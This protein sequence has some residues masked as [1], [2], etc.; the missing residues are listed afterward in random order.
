MT[1]KQF[2]ILT[3]ALF[4]VIIMSG[5]AGVTTTNGGVAPVTMGMNL[6]SDVSGN[7]ILQPIQGQD[8]QIVKRNV[9]ACGKLTSFFTAIT[10]GDVSY[11]TLK[12]K[13]LQHAPGAHDLID[14]K[15]DYHMKNMCGINE[16]TVTLTGTAVKFK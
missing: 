10:M 5:C 8:Y 2:F 15:M 6:Y 1:M 3:A 16:V 13:A 4:T 11:C 7:A 12:K 9:T 14:V